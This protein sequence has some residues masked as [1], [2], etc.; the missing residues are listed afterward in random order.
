MDEEKHKCHTCD[1]HR[2]ISGRLGGTT[3]NGRT[4]TS[5]IPT[6][7]VLAEVKELP[8][9]TFLGFRGPV[10][11]LCQGGSALMCLDCGT[12]SVSLTAEIEQAKKVVKKSAKRTVAKAYKPTPREQS[13]VSEFVHDSRK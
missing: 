10:V 2:V 1:S 9:R 13:A 12:V 5:D 8:L 3:E 4:I 6:S 11:P 7:F